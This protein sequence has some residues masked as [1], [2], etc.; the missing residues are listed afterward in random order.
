MTSALGWLK[1]ET[2][3][4]PR[5]Q[6]FSFKLRP[7]NSKTSTTTRTRFSQ[8]LVV[9]ARESVSFW[10]EKV[11][12]LVTLLQSGGNKLANVGSFITL[13]SRERVT[14]SLTTDNSVNFLVKNGKMKLSGKSIF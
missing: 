4:Q 10:R 11:V 3:E 6:G 2:C 13:R 8:Y 9:L 1:G 12:A 5:S 7:L 14:S